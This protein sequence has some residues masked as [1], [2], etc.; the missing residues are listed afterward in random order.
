MSKAKSDF[1]KSY[2]DG[3]NFL[4]SQKKNSLNHVVCQTKE[5]S[6]ARKSKIT[7]GMDHLWDL[8]DQSFCKL[9][10]SPGVWGYSSRNDPHPGFWQSGCRIH[11]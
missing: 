3:R 2:D 1:L 7:L 4:A 5:R 8:L 9:L 6:D 10:G 11:I